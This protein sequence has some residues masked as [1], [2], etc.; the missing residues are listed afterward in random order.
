MRDKFVETLLGEVKK[1]P[2]IILIT[3]DLG[4]GVLD[5]F[6]EI[7]PDNFIN[8]GVAEQNMAGIAAG[9]AF[10][11]KIVFTYSIAN[12]PTMRCYEQIRNDICYHNL[13]V[14][15]VSVGGGFSYGSLGM[16]HHATEDLAVMRCLPNMTM[17]SPSGLWET[18]EATRAL[19]NKTGPGFLR[20]DKSV[21]IDSPLFDNEKFILGNPRKM[22]DG[23]DCTLFVTGGILSE[24]QKAQKILM[25]KGISIK[26]I[27]IHTIK[28][29][30][31][32]SIIDECD[33]TKA[34]VTLEE[35]TIDGGLGSILSEIMADNQ[36]AG[37]KFLRIGLDKGFSSVV[38]SQEYL[39]KY[40]KMDSESVVKKIIKLLNIES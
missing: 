13:N 6:R 36:I 23:S 24:A 7:Y 28:P 1:N 33:E 15:I 12:F 18:S 11:G 14:N 34:I 35:H 29:I 38:G 5:D 40:Y 26:I 21:A 10:E 16:S 3:G 4:F 32:N 31:I 20:L 17:L 25:K 9:L 30:N 2:N 8:A 22:T 19:I 37:K 39:R 27:N